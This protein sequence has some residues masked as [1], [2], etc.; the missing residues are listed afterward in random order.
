MKRFSILMTVIFFSAL[1]QAGSVSQNFLQS[2][3]HHG[4]EIEMKGLWNDSNGDKGK[5]TSTLT[6][7]KISD[8]DDDTEGYKVSVIEVTKVYIGEE[9]RE[10]EDN[11]IAVSIGNGFFDI[12]EDEK[13]TGD[14]YC[15]KH[16]CHIQ[17]PKSSV[18]ETYK[19]HRKGIKKMGSMK[20]EELRVKWAGKGRHA[21]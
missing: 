1:L 19:F 5:W 11:Y 9:V 7:K 17:R 16:V 6:V 21:R 14:A 20:F 8:D 12:Y 2:F 18:E 3:D 10:M 4:K 13:L 15:F